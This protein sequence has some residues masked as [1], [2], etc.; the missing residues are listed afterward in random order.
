MGNHTLAVTLLSLGSLCLELLDASRADNLH[1]LELITV[2]P[3][4]LF[5]LLI[6]LST[7]GHESA[8][9]RTLS[10]ENVGTVNTIG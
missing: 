2:H 10:G 3:I 4:K 1:L 8:T 5:Q 9:E 6:N 7:R